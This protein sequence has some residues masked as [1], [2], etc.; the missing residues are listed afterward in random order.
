MLFRSMLNFERVVFASNR[1]QPVQP[2]ESGILITQAQWK[3]PPNELARWMLADD[4]QA[5]TS[6]PANFKRAYVDYLVAM[7]AKH[8]GPF[9]Q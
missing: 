9:F 5:T 3:F 7:S 8:G 4:L 1:E 6:V 2:G